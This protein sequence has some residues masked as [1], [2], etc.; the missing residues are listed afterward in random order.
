MCFSTNK[1]EK[2]EV[3]AKKKLID[4]IIKTPRPT[5]LMN[6]GF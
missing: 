5:C 6:S 1:K 2:K 3:V 4:S